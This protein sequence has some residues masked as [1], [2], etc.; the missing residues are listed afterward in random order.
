MIQSLLITFVIQVGFTQMMMGL[1]QV[2]LSF[3]MSIDQNLNKIESTFERASSCIL[4]LS[5]Y[6]SLRL[7]NIISSKSL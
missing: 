5:F 6:S 1:N 7:E 3:T 2:E 4:L